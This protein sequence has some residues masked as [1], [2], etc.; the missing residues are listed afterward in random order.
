MYFWNGREV[1]EVSK[2][3]YTSNCHPYV[4]MPCVDTKLPNGN[5]SRLGMFQRSRYLVAGKSDRYDWNNMRVDTYPPEFRVHLLLL[6][7][8]L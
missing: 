8:S 2:G 3:I 4:D 6:G 1:I 5:A 7:V